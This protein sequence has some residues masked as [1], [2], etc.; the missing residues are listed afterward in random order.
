MYYAI[1][2]KT[3]LIFGSSGLVGNHLFDYILKNN[4]YQKN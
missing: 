4:H 2:M 1:K 3:A